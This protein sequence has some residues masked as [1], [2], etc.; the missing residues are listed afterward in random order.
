VKDPNAEGSYV[1]DWDDGSEE[2]GESGEGGD[3]G[4]EIWKEEVKCN[5]VTVKKEV[6]LETDSS[7]ITITSVFHPDADSTEIFTFFNKYSL[8]QRRGYLG[9]NTVDTENSY[10]LPFKL[11]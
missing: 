11:H 3:D 6:T 7:N 5:V 10:R 9:L 4:D 8:V 2:P 1:E